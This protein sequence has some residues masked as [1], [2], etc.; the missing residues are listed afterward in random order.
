MT[1]TATSSDPRPAT[2]AATTPAAPVPLDSLDQLSARTQLMVDDYDPTNATPKPPVYRT[3]F[4][5]TRPD[6][7]PQPNTRVRLWASEVMSVTIDGEVHTL[8]SSPDEAPSFASDALGLLSLTY[9][10]N[11]IS[12]PILHSST[13]RLDVFSTIPDFQVLRTLGDV[14][15]PDL[16]PD[17]AQD[18]AGRPI[19]LEMYRNPTSQT[20]L[21]D[22]IRN[23]IGRTSPSNARFETFLAGD[24]M[25]DLVDDEGNQTIR[26]NNVRHW[27]L[28]LGDQAS[29]MPSDTDV[30]T[31][32]TAASQIQFG[33]FNDFKDFVDDVVDAGSDVVQTVANWADDSVDFLVETA[34]K[35]YRFTVRTVK[36][37]VTVLR[38]VLRSVVE[39]I[40]QVI[41]WLSFLFDWGDILRTAGAIENLVTG[42]LESLRRQLD[43][44]LEDAIRSTRSF[45]EERE[46]DIEQ[47]LR[48]IGTSHQASLRTETGNRRPGQLFV[49]GGRDASVPFRWLMNR[50]GLSGSSADAASAFEAALGAGQEAMLGKI[51]DFAQQSRT[52]VESDPATQ[53]FSDT[54]MTTLDDLEKFAETFPSLG[55]ASLQELLE[56]FGDIAVLT[57][58]AASKVTTLFLQLLKELIDAVIGALTGSLPVDI[59]FLSP[60]FRF[61]TGKELS[62]V[63]L[64]ALLVAVPTTLVFK[65]VEGRSPVSF[66]AEPLAAL[67]VPD[68]AGLATTFAFLIRSG[69]EILVDLRV[70]GGLG[71]A[72]NVAVITTIWGLSVFNAADQGPFVVNTLVAYLTLF[73]ILVGAAL[74]VAGGAARS[75][76]SAIG[77]FV[78][79]V[80]GIVL[81]LTYTAL[82]IAP[83]GV[84]TDNVARNLT[85][86]SPLAGKALIRVPDLGPLIVGG[87]DFGG[88]TIAAILSGVSAQPG[89]AVAPAA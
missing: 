34:K 58:K 56:V 26:P 68:Y 41:Q 74:L 33:I 77:P 17:K 39:A 81:S 84:Y 54:L 22:A 2:D 20:A 80:Y 75:S 61:L 71:L 12:A 37:A 24:N 62:V 29:F 79:T 13:E 43:G 86:A 23:T 5:T 36:E 59:P 35:A 9:D 15:G 8:P 31:A 76:Y 48:Q 64:G 6:G 88:F 78:S 53:G 4:S 19:L 14:Q 65:A 3:Q 50:A 60:L 44:S 7:S 27:T 47:A 30:L 67:T 1:Q 45:F 69:T 63:R 40:E 49:G 25:A 32:A 55:S 51:Q 52:M 85:A 28:R 11:D 82:A 66:T 38:G 21:A 73:P 18:Y 57:M 70:A 46:A 10:A 42:K 72:A 16:A 89:T 83:G 87:L